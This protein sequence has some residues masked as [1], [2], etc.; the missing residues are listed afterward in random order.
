MRY[1]IFKIHPRGDDVL[2][3]YISKRFKRQPNKLHR[4]IESCSGY[5]VVT[6]SSKKVFT[7]ALRHLDAE[8]L[9]AD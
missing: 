2:T 3:D 8:N 5:I 1:Y 4:Q 7:F 6:V 9:M